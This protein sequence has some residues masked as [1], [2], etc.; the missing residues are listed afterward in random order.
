M[1]AVNSSEDIY[2]LLAGNE[3]G[4]VTLCGFSVAPII[5]DPPKESPW[6]HLTKLIPEGKRVCPDCSARELEGIDR[7]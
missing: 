4:E 7:D 1:Y 3:A 2:H 5:I 6:L